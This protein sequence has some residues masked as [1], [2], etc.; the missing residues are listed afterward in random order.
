M[1]YGGTAKIDDCNVL[2][3]CLAGELKMLKLK[4]RVML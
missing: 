2:R 1:I 3:T 4:K